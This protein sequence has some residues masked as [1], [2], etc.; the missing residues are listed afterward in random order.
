[1]SGN[2]SINYN[3]TI[4]ELY[5]I[6]AAILLGELCYKYDYWI[7][8]NRTTEDGYFFVTQ[9]DIEKETGLS[10]YQQRIAL[11]ELKEIVSVKKRGLP[12]KNY[13]KIFYNKLSKIL[14]Q[15]IKDFDIRDERFSQ[16]EVKAFDS[17]NKE[18]T[19]KDNTNKENTNI[20]DNNYLNNSKS[21]VMV[22]S[23]IYSNYDKDL[24]DVIIKWYN[25]VGISRKITFAQIQD[26]LEQLKKDCSNDAKLVV[27]QINNSYLNNY[28]N[29]YP[30]KVKQKSVSNS[31]SN[32]PGE[33][34]RSG[35]RDYI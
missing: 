18:I 4:A 28:P 30:P 21:T 34:D 7:E 33:I 19:N 32:A 20:S 2:G 25:A 35:Y 29:W 1:M 17:T 14:T 23:Q 26:K 6:Y 11:E 13:Y 27:Q 3:K 10:P 12:S 9:D 24:A 16:Q 8:N 22:R 31:V 15:E 5:G